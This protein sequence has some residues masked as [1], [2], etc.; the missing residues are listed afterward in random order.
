LQANL[1]GFDATFPAPPRAAAVTT[2]IDGQCSLAEIA[3][4][5]QQTDPALS[6]MDA[7][8]FVQETFAYL[9][10]LNIALL[11]NSQ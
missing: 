4:S 2:R 8:K 7:Q 11:M 3:A 10:N 9:N 5:L 6:A 1:E